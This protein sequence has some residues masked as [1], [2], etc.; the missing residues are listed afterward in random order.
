MSPYHPQ[1][2]GILEKSLSF[3]RD[4]YSKLDWEDTL[5]LSVYSYRMFPDIHSVESPFFLHCGRDSLTLKDFLSPTLRYQEDEKG[6]I[7]LESM[8]YGLALVRKTSPLADKSLTVDKPLQD[9]PTNLKLETLYMLK[10]IPHPGG[11]QN[12]NMNCELLN[13]LFPTV[14]YWRPL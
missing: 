12:G 10:D 3:P 6:F 9:H 8:R 7:D 4:V 14:L 11:T 1:S 5:Q 13:F 2:T